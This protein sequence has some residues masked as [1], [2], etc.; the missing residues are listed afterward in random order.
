MT[1]IFPWQSQILIDLLGRW[2]AGTLPHALLFNGAT[3][4]GKVQFAEQWAALMLCDKVVETVSSVEASLDNLQ[5]CGQ[6]QGC[7]LMKAGTHPDIKRIY[8]DD[9]KAIPVD[10]V[11][12][13]SRYLSLKSQLAQMQIVIIS[14]AEKMNRFSANSL[15][16]TLEEPTPNTLLILVT[17]RPAN[18]LPT[19]R[20]RCQTIAFA[21]PST[22]AA[23]Q[24]LQQQCQQQ[25]L[26]I[27]QQQITELLYLTNQ[28]PLTALA[29]ARSDA[30]THRQT[31]LESLVKLSNQTADPIM[32]TT[33]WSSP[34]VTQSLQWL[35]LWTMDMI[36]LKS[37]A[38]GDDK[39][40]GGTISTLKKLS[41]K[42]D[43]QILFK[44]LDKLTESRRLLDT[45][46]N[47]QLLLEDVLIGW[48]RISKT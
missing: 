33:A 16:K 8:S 13:V 19:I 39:S 11:R 43:L 20:S 15:L 22:E 31:L 46:V 41:E 9:G 40:T 47:Q 7:K 24:W 28:S 29:Y 44:F 45:Q 34:N 26:T 5:T 38:I 17:D 4:I 36:R 2:R 3:G 25:G 23:S 6:C 35:L 12:E 18:L 48:S 42:I 30:L 1:E 27:D 37:D 14:P 32:E 21:Q 10:S